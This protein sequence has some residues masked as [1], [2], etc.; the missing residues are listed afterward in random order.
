MKHVHPW[1]IG[2]FALI[3]LL[4]S[5][6]SG[7]GGSGTTNNGPIALK[8][9]YTQSG[10]QAVPILKIV[11]DFN[12]SHPTIHVSAQAVD[13]G[14]IHDQFAAAAKSGVNAPDVV[15]ID[16]AWIAEFASA[17]YLLDLTS[18]AQN[19]QDFVPAALAS[20]TYQGK[21]WALPDTV[22]FPVMYYNQ[23]L[24]NGAGLSQPPASMDDLATDAAK[25]SQGNAGQ[26][27]FATEGTTLFVTPFLLADG[28]DLVGSD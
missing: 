28:G 16:D 6:C 25:L 13:V 23:A 18:R 10:S 15:R 3:A 14:S 4:V 21:V 22:E 26:Y 20:V 5:A 11:S 12:A 27:G 17:N 2:L 8:F 19:T 1:A 7:N 9:W 24:L